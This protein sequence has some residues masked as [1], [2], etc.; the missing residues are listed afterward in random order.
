MPTPD[1]KKYQEDTARFFR[2]L[3]F[4]AKTDVTVEG[5]R[6]RHDVDVVATSD[7]AGL[8]QLWVVECKL[9]QRAVGKD[10]VLV[11]A[12]IVTDVGADRGILLS[13]SG[14]QAGALRQARQ[15]NITLTSLADLRENAEEEAGQIALTLA[16]RRI[17][18]L[19]GRA[20]SLTR[21]ETTHHSAKTY[22]LPGVDG[23]GLTELLGRLSLTQSG[24]LK[25]STNEVPTLISAPT[26]DAVVAT[27]I[28][29]A[30]DLASAVANWAEG[31]IEEQ[32]KRAADAKR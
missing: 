1:W 31:W 30:A 25:A 14:F 16:L 23:R 21:T 5:A 22:T 4:E 17:T 27:T 11:L 13:E 28:R 24:L 9:W 3:G 8:R 7:R 12:H 26:D 29:E 15:S 20:H 2:D 6:G 32:E 18:L 10:R 19:I